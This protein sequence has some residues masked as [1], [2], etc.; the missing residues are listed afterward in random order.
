MLIICYFAITV[1][2]DTIFSA[3]SW[4]TAPKSLVSPKLGLTCSSCGIGK[5]S[6]HAPSFEH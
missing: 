3:S 4:M 5:D 6:G 1:M 2:V